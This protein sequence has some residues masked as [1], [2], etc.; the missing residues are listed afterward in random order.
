MNCGA[1][2]RGQLHQPGI[3]QRCNVFGYG[4]SAQ[5][6]A[7]VDQAHAQLEQRLIVSS[8]KLIYHGETDW[9]AQRSENR[10]HENKISNLLVANQSGSWVEIPIAVRATRTLCCLAVARI[11][12]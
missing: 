11:Y 8:R 6:V 9:I 12:Y 5:A 4:L 10:I 2:A 1:A 3:P 7:S